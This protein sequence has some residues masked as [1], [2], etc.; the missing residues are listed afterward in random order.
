MAHNVLVVT[1][2]ELRRAVALDMAAIEA[3]ERAFVALATGKVV[4]PPILAMAI[5]DANG[6]VDVKSAY[7]P[8]VDSLAVKISPGFFDNPKIGLADL[9]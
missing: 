9:V 4:M 6:E 3:T 5:A 8:G 1:E 2:T 7:I